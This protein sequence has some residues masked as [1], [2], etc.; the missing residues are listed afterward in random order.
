MTWLNAGIHQDRHH[1]REIATINK[2][3][4]LFVK[5]EERRQSFAIRAVFVVVVV[6]FHEPCATL[7][8]WLSW[9]H[10]FLLEAGPD[11]SVI[12][13]KTRGGLSSTKLHHTS[14]IALNNS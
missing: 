6:G 8:L 11:H 9:M 3:L 1:T 7:A 13:R 5:N 4:E 10:R 2:L 12:K 14:K